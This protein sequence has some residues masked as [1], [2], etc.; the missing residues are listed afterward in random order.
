M[1]GKLRVS[2]VSEIEECFV[3]NCLALFGEAYLYI[4][5]NKKVTIDWDEENISAFFFEYIDKSE[6]A[7]AL[8]IN[9]SDE[10]RLFYADI[11]NGKKKAKAASRIDFRLTTN[12][13]EQKKR[14]EYYVE[15]KNLIE[16]DCNKEGRKSKLNAR[17]SQERYIT[18]GID[19]IISG[20]YP[21]RSCL[22]GYVLQGNPNE[23]V[24]K[25]NNHLLL[26]GRA[27]EQLQIFESNI[28]NLKSCYHSNHTNDHLLNHFL[29]RFSNSN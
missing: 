17:K 28:E 27:T 21:P 10:H 1:A 23:I 19:N 13:L 3:N 20:K 16:D 24:N 11:L 14:L 18:T 6:K 4:R 29:L 12:W 15:A 9:I 2:I 7:I 8:N 25:I 22:V 5:E 26:K